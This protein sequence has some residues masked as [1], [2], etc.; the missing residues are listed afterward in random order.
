VVVHVRLAGMLALEVPVRYVRVVHRRVVVLVLMCGAEVLEAPGH[1]VAVV[2]HMEMPVGM[3][4]P[5][6]SCSSHPAAGAFS[7]MANSFRH[8][9]SALPATC[10]PGPSG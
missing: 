5:L 2:R 4:Q 1:L 3:H 9:G 8:H 10:Y 6:G 7:V